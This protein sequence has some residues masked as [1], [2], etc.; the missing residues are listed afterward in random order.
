MFSRQ[1]CSIRTFK[2]SQLTFSRHLC[3]SSRNQS[4]SKNSNFAN[5]STGAELEAKTKRRNEVLS[6]TRVVTDEIECSDIVKSIMML[7]EPVAVDMEVVTSIFLSPKLPTIIQKFVYFSHP[8]HPRA[9]K[10]SCEIYI[11]HLKVEK[12]RRDGRTYFDSP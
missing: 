8:Y 10:G 1:I 3:S 5:N 11:C 9:A 4:A 2:Q 7:G 12:Y 6:R